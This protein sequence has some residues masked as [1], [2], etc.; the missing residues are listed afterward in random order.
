MKKC[1]LFVDDDPKILHGLKLTL[2]PFRKEWDIHFANSGEE[3]LDFLQGNSC[4]CIVSDMRMPG[5]DGAEFLLQ[6]KKLAPAAHRFVLSGHADEEPIFRSVPVTHQFI[7][8]P[9][10]SDKIVEK[11][12]NAFDIDSLLSGTTLKTVIGNI[13]HLPC[14]PQVY[15]DVCAKLEAEDSSLEDV[16]VVISE[17]IGLSSGI[18]K[19]VNSAFFGLPQKINQVK[20]AVAFLGV[21]TVKSLVLMHGA[22]SSF[23]VKDQSG[24]SFDNE[25]RLSMQT[26]TVAK[27]I[28]NALGLP[29]VEESF[30]IAML[31]RIG[32]LIMAQYMPDKFQQLL[33]ALPSAEVSLGELEKQYIGVTHGQLG[34]YLLGLWG[35]PMPC[36]QAVAYHKA[37]WDMP[38]EQAE[39]VDVLYIACNLVE[40]ND[41]LVQEKVEYK[42][43]FDLDYLEKLDLADKLTQWQKLVDE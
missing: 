28:A 42:D 41:L 9:C 10:S 39:L 13:D 8:K 30:T 6:A 31:H 2:R 18:L 20:D 16:A 14:R 40:Y 12:K 4:D 23:P 32:R 5:I 36:V 38:H 17:D 29:Q 7:L 19:V 3:A 25:H 1:V 15:A 34:A 43:I 33:E 11:I 27:A 26:A 22:Q 21:Q 24:F 37:P 35:I